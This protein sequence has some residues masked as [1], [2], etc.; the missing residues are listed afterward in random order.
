MS[1]SIEQ[2]REKA[3][4][5]ARRLNTDAA[6][7]AQLEKHPEE[8]LV[9]AGFPADGVAEFL[10]EINLGESE[11]SGYLDHCLCSVCCITG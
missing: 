7:K 5:I 1:E 6:F 2:V 8:T 11:V 4:A 9:A 3:V 10:A